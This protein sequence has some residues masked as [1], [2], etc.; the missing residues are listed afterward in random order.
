MTYS[1]NSVCTFLPAISVKTTVI[2]SW[3]EWTTVV[4]TVSCTS[5]LCWTTEDSLDARKENI[6]HQF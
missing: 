3:T 4:K 5:L 2:Y 1:T 6:V